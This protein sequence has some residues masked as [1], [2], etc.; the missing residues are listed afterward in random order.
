MREQFWLRTKTM[1]MKRFL[2]ISHELTRINTK[3]FNISCSFRVLSRLISVF[4][5]SRQFL[6]TFLLLLTALFAGCARYGA[7]TYVYVTNERDGTISV[8]DGRTEKVVDTI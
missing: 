7:G 5:Q 4:L 3:K 8:I 6:L 2:R 1:K